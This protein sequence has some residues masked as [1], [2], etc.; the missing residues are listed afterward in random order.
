MEHAVLGGIASDAVAFSIEL[1]SS[2]AARVLL[3]GSIR[4][5]LRRRPPWLFSLVPL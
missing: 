5:F 3:R 1:Q 4:A 2:V